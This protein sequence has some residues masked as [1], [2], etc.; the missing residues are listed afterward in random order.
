[1]YNDCLDPSQAGGVVF[2][3]VAAYG[4]Y[5]VVPGLPEHTLNLQVTVE[6]TEGSVQDLNVDTNKYSKLQRRMIEAV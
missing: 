5:D 3:P 1:M 4:S 6:L 2:A